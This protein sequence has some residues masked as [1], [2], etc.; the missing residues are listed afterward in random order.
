[1]LEPQKKQGKVVIFCT[2][3]Q[4]VLSRW[5]RYVA[6]SGKKYEI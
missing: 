3:K 6:C 5:S 4:A 2:K 1:M